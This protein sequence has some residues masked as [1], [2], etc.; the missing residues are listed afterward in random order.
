[1]VTGNDISTVG[2]ERAVLRASVAAADSGV[3]FPAAVAILLHVPFLWSSDGEST[4]FIFQVIFPFVTC[5]W[6]IFSVRQWQRRMD[7][8]L[9]AADTRYLH[10]P[11]SI[12]GSDGGL[13][14]LLRELFR[15]AH[16]VE[17]G[18]LVGIGAMTSLFIALQV[19]CG[20][21]LGHI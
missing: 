21:T 4:G 7:A 2:A 13:T 1:V 18:L 10:P 8:V 20:Y 12:S 11:A 3:I 5:L 17:F 19:R 15:S 14:G 16:I 9:A 6:V